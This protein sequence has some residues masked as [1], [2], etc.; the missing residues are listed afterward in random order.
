MQERSDEEFRLLHREA[1]R[2]ELPVRERAQLARDLHHETAEAWGVRRFG[3]HRSGR[4]VANVRA[5]EILVKTSIRT[6]TAAVNDRAVY[7]DS[8][9]A[10]GRK[11]ETTQFGASTTSLIFR[12]TATLQR[13]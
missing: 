13:T 1:E 6:G 8:K 3:E 5:S 2:R 10:S 11:A 7:V 12:S 9:I 4:H